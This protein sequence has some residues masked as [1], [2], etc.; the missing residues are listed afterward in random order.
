MAEQS[1]FGKGFVLCLVK[2]AAHFMSDLYDR[3]TSEDKKRSLEIWGTEERLE[4]SRVLLW[5]SG[6]SDHLY[7][8][9]APSGLQWDGVRAKVKELQEL[10]L[11]MGHGYNE[12][13]MWK[14]ENKFKLM[15]LTHEIAIETDKI[16]GVE[17]EVGRW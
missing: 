2:F 12:E 15:D 9:K 17:S 3:E 5:A 1:E 4:T 8:I 11:K 16:L 7:E 10:G 13:V 6:A 14:K